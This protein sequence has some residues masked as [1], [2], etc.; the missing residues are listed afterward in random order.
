MSAD[1]AALG[2]AQAGDTPCTH[3]C[4]HHVYGGRPLAC[5]RVLGHDCQ[6]PDEKRETN[7]LKRGG[8]GTA[9]AAL[10]QHLGVVDGQPVFFEARC[11][12]G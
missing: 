8:H 2:A 1:L 10:D 4:G 11:C 3:S 7:C 12:N 6:H 9:A 5:I